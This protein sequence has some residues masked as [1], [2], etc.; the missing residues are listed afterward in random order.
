[1]VAKLDR[2]EEQGE[3]P[4]GTDTQALARFYSAILQG[5]SVQAVDGAS[6]AVLHRT[7]DLALAAWPGKRPETQTQTE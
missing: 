2:A 6:A 3:L 1:M 7:V 4:A 5:M